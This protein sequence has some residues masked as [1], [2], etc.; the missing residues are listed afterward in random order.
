MILSCTVNHRN[1]MRQLQ[2]AL[3]IVTDASSEAGFL[4]TPVKSKAMWFFGLNPDTNLHLDNLPVEWEDHY[5]Y[6]G[7][8]IDKHLRFH[9]HVECIEARTNSSATRSRC[10]HHY[11]E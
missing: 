7:V 11:R 4:F 6:L 8:A 10:L 3:D 9:R 2:A 1:P 5:N